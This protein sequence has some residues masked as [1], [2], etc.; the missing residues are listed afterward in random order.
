MVKNCPKCCLSVCLLETNPLLFT[1][2]RLKIIGLNLLK[3]N[4]LIT[5]KIVISLT[6]CSINIWISKLLRN[7]QEVR[8]GASQAL[9]YIKFIAVFTR[10]WTSAQRDG[11]L[12]EY[13]W[14]RLQRR[15]VWLTPTTRVPCSN[16]AKMRNPLS[17][18]GAPNSPTDLSQPVLGQSSPYCEDMWGRYCCLTFFS[19]C[20]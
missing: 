17:F 1:L 12:A 7:R 3:R 16:A 18:W 14:Y 15:K 2:T 19:D 4:L 13:S 6:H 10:M 11:R 5:P 9:Q 20:R 8:N